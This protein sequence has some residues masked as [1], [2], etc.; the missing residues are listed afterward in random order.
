MFAFPHR[1]HEIE[2]SMDDGARV[3]LDRDDDGL[4]EGPERPLWF[5]EPLMFETKEEDK[6]GIA[7]CE[8]DRGDEVE[9]GESAIG[10]PVTWCGR[11]SL[12]PRVHKCGTVW[13][14]SVARRLLVCDDDSD[15]LGAA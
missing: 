12:D 9:V 3:I 10:L 7:L 1:L 11:R 14:D 8:M 2:G 6:G 13:S 5:D 4:E 15:A